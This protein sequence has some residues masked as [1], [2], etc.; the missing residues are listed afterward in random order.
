MQELPSGA[1]AP[2]QSF[3]HLKLVLDG[4]SDGIFIYDGNSTLIACNEKACAT[5]DCSERE[6]LGRNVSELATLPCVKEFIGREFVG[7]SLADIRRRH[8][9]VENYPSPGYMRFESGRKMLYDIACVRDES[10][11]LLYAVTT[12]REATDLNEARGEIDKLERLTRFYDDQLR[13]LHVQLVGKELIA[14][15]KAMQEVCRRALRFAQLDSNLMVTGATGTGKTL[16]ARYIHA[17]GRR[18]GKPFQSLNCA[19]LPEPLVEAELFGY[20]EGAF[21]GAAR[22]GRCGLLESARGG[23]VF[24]D[25]ISEMP[26]AVQAK[27]LIAVDEKCI[28][29]VGGR[30]PIPVDVRFVSAT[31][32]EPGELK[33]LLRE[34]LFY[35]LSTLRLQ[36][37]S[38]RER[39]DDVAPLVEQAVAEYNAEN[40]CNVAL[41]AEVVRAL[42][43]HPLPG[44][45]RQLRALVWQIAAEAGDGA[46][47]IGL[48]GLPAALRAELLGRAGEAHGAAGDTGED[49]AAPS[50]EERFFRELSSTHAGDV[51]AM[52]RSLKVHRTTVLR[53]LR[54]YAIPYA[55]ARGKA[56]FRTEAV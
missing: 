36:V 20:V 40:A 56:P 6:L 1:K 42:V 8:K 21:T 12:I 16:L 10:G 50:D 17:T 38:L 55:G 24:L 29:R 19:S 41:S 11:A 32:R 44:N 49:A 47:A 3:E 46:G 35:R 25:E 31:N 54:R 45:I 4:I 53:K 48:G 5:F 14:T 2:L 52:A 26:R 22:G 28:R 18:A 23:T 13:T 34:D 27:L 43:A 37:P 15:S 51:Y 7:L 33:S 9:R 39:Q 30:E